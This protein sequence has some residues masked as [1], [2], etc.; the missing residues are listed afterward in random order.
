MTDEMLT[1]PKEE[2]IYL[3]TR[4][5][6]FNADGVKDVLENSGLASAIEV[7]MIEIERSHARSDHYKEEC[8]RLRDDVHDLESIIDKY[9]DM[10]K[11]ESDRWLNM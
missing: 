8:S 6:I 1:I 5:D 4:S 3:L 7:L 2:F 9:E 10:S 11:S